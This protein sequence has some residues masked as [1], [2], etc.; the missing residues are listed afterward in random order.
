MDNGKTLSENS[1]RMEFIVG[2]RQS[3]GKGSENSDPEY[4]SRTPT[5]SYCEGHTAVPAKVP[6]EIP[7]NGGAVIVH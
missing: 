5:Q 2:S 7:V 4:D 3:R 6:S 1:R